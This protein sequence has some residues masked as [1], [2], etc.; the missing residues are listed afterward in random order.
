M[1]RIE[2]FLKALNL[3]AGI[4]R[5]AAGEL[6]LKFKQG[7]LS[8]ATMQAIIT[9]QPTKPVGFLRHSSSLYSCVIQHQDQIILLG[10]TIITDVSQLIGQRGQ[11]LFLPRF[12]NTA[13]L[14]T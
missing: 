2:N 4:W 11:V 3:P 14:T 7:G 6:T 13:S 12:L 9:A 5:Q 10:P 1:S 8:T